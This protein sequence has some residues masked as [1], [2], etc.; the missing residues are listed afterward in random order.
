MS[1]WLMTLIAGVV[2]SAIGGLLMLIG[3]AEWVGILGM[4]VGGASIF[5]GLVGAGVW[6]GTRDLRR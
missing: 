6:M 1:T 2:I 5:A 3:T 4:G